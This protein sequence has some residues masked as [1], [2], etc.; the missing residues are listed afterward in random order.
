MFITLNSST[1]SSGERSS[2][3]AS[4]IHNGNIRQSAQES[5]GKLHTSTDEV[6]WSA[7]NRLPVSVAGSLLNNNGVCF[8]SCTDFSEKISGPSL[9]RWCKL[10]LQFHHLLFRINFV[11][12]IGSF[13]WE[14]VQKVPWKAFFRSPA[15]WAMIYAHFCGNWGHYSLLSWLPTY[16]RWRLFL[17]CLYSWVF[18]PQTFLLLSFSS[19]S[20]NPKHFW[21]LF[22][23]SHYMRYL[24]IVQSEYTLWYVFLLDSDS[25]L[26]CKVAVLDTWT[27]HLDPKLLDKSLM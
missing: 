16:F 24:E 15:V 23:A 5:N 27:W 3:G 4:H 11:C 20:L 14:S 19:W 13:I 18:V 10:L 1:G 26:I 25:L 9:G 22:R 6:R 17:L 8:I 7:I 21:S 12:F 2:N